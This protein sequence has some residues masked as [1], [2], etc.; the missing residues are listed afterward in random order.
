VD[1]LFAR[2]VSGTISWYLTDRLGSVRTITDV[3]GNVLDTINYDGFGNVTSESN[4]SNGD[5]YKWT[6]RESMPRQGFNTIAL[7]NTI[8]D[9]GDGSHKPRSALLEGI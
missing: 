6:G 5:R 1:Q 9:S 2:S 7:G 3:S 8:L 4:T